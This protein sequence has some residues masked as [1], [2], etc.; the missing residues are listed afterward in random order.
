MEDVIW[1][2]P[3]VLHLSLKSTSGLSSIS[4]GQ[5]LGG[6][7]RNCAVLLPYLLHHHTTALCSTASSSSQFK[8]RPHICTFLL[9]SGD[10]G[11]T[12]V[13]SS[14]APAHVNPA[15]T[16]AHLLSTS[17]PPAGLLLSLPPFVS[18]HLRD[19]KQI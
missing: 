10:T 11:L 5:G 17:H 18:S 15:T 9:I 12:D 4:D 6:K 16:S 14:I 1:L 2:E 7:Q 19:R 13:P 3:V 8:S